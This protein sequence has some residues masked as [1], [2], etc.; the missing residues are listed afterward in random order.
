MV[1]YFASVVALLVY[2][3]PLY[4][5]DPALRASQADLTQARAPCALPPARARAPALA[6]CTAHGGCAPANLRAAA[7]GWPDC[8]GCA[9]AEAGGSRCA[10]DYIRSMRLLQNTSRCAPPAGTGRKCS[11]GSCQRGACAISSPNPAS[12]PRPSLPH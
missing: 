11:A 3:A 4:F 12:F 2:A 10:Q 8:R 7:D 9:A 5:R 6:G 1:K